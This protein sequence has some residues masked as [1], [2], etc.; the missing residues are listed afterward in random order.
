MSL[1][2]TA[3]GRVG[4][5]GTSEV[6]AL[7]AESPTPPGPTSGGSS[8]EPPA[9]GW[10]TPSRG[11]VDPVAT[12]PPR[13]GGLELALDLPE[14]MAVGK[15]APVDLALRGSGNTAI[16]IQQAAPAGVQP[17]TP[18]C[19]RW[20]TPAGSPRSRPRMARSRSTSRPNRQARSSPR[21]SRSSHPRRQAPRVC[22]TL[23]TEPPVRSLSMP[24]L[25]SG[26]S[27]PRRAHS[28][29]L[30]E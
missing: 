12:Q 25:R 5:L 26:R 18:H 3:G 1:L 2:S 9:R 16:V 21:N 20:S 8:A 19:K 17:S 6:T 11:A 10:R 30:Q 7:V 28:P 24:R 4:E 29:V 15:T 14:L 22:S 27:Q 13:G 23:D